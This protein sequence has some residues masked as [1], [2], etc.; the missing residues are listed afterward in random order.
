MVELS[1][2]PQW[3]PGCGDFGILMALKKALD[4]LGIEPHRT[5]IVSGIGCSGKFPHYIRTYGFEGIHGRGLAV[6]TGIKLANPELEVISV[7]GDGDGYGIG[8]NHFIHAARR[9]IDIVGIGFNNEVYGLTTG[10]ASP[11][12]RIGL[13]TKTTPSGNFERPVNPIMLALGAGAT[14]V[15]RGFA[16]DIPHLSELIK[17]AIQHKGFGF[18]DVVQP[19][20]TWF[21]T[22]DE[23]RKRL[24]RIED[25]TDFMKAVKYASEGLDGGRMPAGVIYKEERETF[26][27]MYGLRERLSKDVDVEKMIEE[28]Y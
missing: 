24:Y 4:S 17:K 1:H 16:G 5:V 25:N 9:N 6:A 7:F 2:K 21:N 18:I 23:M 27:E 22:Y 8:G 28:F 14:F 10:Q 26:E 20:V 19:C 12:T 13:K 3:C 11:T 15:A